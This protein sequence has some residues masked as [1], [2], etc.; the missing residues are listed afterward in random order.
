MAFSLFSMFKV[1]RKIIL[2]HSR[3]GK[4]IYKNWTSIR[5]NEKNVLSN[6]SNLESENIQC[7]IEQ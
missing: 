1:Y 6:M 2:S 7:L 5:S 3:Y 4:D